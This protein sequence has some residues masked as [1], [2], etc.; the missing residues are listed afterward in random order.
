MLAVKLIL[1]TTLICK[2]GNTFYFGLGKGIQGREVEEE[3][4]VSVIFRFLS[5]SIRS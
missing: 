5:A 3:G 1:R 4:L 2:L